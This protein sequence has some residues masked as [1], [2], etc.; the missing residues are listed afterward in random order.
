M[1]TMSAMLQ[2]SPC[3]PLRCFVLI[4]LLLR[5]TGAAQAQ[6]IEGV[7]PA[8]L[9]QPRINLVLRRQAKGPALA[10]KVMGEEAFNVEAFLDTGASSIV[11]ST[12]SAAQL[13][14]KR[15]VAG[16]GEA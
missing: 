7:Q 5:L 6:D 10:G 2:R 12:N 15:E 13:G 11:L 3:R 8:A 1:D 9:D 14:V 16:G 4:L